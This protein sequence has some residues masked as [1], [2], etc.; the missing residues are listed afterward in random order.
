MNTG[1][2]QIL[3]IFTKMDLW[4]SWWFKLKFGCF[5]G[6][7][8]EVALSGCSFSNRILQNKIWLIT[9]KSF[10]FQ[11]NNQNKPQK[12]TIKCKNFQNDIVTFPPKLTLQWSQ[13]ICLFS[14][15]VKI[16]GCV[17]W[18][19]NTW[20]LPLHSI[21]KPKCMGIQRK[22]SLNILIWPISQNPTVHSAFDPT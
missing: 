8:I 2:S 6:L 13:G 18:A 10:L 16:F 19:W 7:A 12:I 15:D 21:F 22:N 1:Q 20:G 17:F 5:C 11:W 14:H 4:A 3:N 9:S